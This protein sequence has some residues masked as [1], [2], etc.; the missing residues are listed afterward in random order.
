MFFCQNDRHL[1]L[2]AA[3]PCHNQ[4]TYSLSLI[5]IRTVETRLKITGI[6]APFFD[7][8]LHRLR[9]MMMNTKQK[10]E[11]RRRLRDELKSENSS[12]NA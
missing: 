11:E 6:V 10:L 5:L 8:E 3:I 9:M 4:I 12:L 2:S 7:G 1:E